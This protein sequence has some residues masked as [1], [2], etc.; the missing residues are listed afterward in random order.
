MTRP[1]AAVLA[2]RRPSGGLVLTL[3]NPGELNAVTGEMRR[4]LIARLE[5]AAAD[6]AVRAVMLRGEGERAFCAG[7]SMADMAAIRDREDC[8]RMGREGA[9]TLN[10]ISEFPKPMI[11]AVSGWCVGDGFELA[12][13]CDLIYA[14]E[15][16]VFCM[17]EIDLGLI[18]GWGGARLLAERI[19]LNP[20]KELMLLGKRLTAAEAGA[21]GLA[22]EV[23]PAG[24]L[25]SRAEQVLDILA[26]KP[27]RAAQGAK[28]LLSRRA[29]ESPYAESQKAGIEAVAELMMTEHFCRTV[30]SFS[31]KR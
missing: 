19:G 21:Y 5:E 9:D 20:A 25:F 3:S 8:L 10:A 15:S 18:M 1:S 2:E 17:P 31:K 29:L 11:A 30:E 28:A 22:A 4:A 7:G 12:L 13:C 27:P 24:E 14:A 16:A 23:L 26:A 6:D